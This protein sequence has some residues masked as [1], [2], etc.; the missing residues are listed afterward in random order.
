[1]AEAGGHGPAAPPSAA[2]AAGIAAGRWQHDAAQAAALV[3]LDRI[4]HDLRTPFLIAPRRSISRRWK[5]W[6]VSG[7]FT[8]VGFSFSESI[9]A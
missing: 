5:K 2:W 9:H 3:E 7:I 6:P 8:S 1:M 4:H